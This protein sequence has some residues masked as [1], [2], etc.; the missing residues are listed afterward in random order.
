MTGKEIIET[1]KGHEDNEILIHLSERDQPHIKY[2]DIPN[3]HGDGYVLC[4]IKIKHAEEIEY[5]GHIF[6]E[7]N[8]IVGG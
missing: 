5:P 1:L 8:I 7:P 6:I 3:K 4:T 2:D